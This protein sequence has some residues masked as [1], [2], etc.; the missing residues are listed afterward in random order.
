MFFNELNG[1][2]VKLAKSA[3]IFEI[4]NKIFTGETVCLEFASFEM[5][6]RI[7]AHGEVGRDTDEIIRW[8]YTD[9]C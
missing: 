9:H 7:P 3:Y 5:T 4:H 6:P 8:P 2:G 1:T